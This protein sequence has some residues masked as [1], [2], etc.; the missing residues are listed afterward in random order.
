MM[1][2]D[3]WKALV[4]EEKH[5][6]VEKALRAAFGTA[7]VEEVTPLTGGG[8]GAAVLKVTVGGVPY[9]LRVI[10][11]VH[12]LND[13]ARQFVC[14][15]RASDAGISPRLHYADAADAVSITDHVAP[16]PL[17]DHPGPPLVA[18]GEAIKAIQATPT[19]PAFVNH[20]DGVDGF[21]RQV[22]AA[23]VLPEG[24][25]REHFALYA[26]LAEAYPRHDPDLVSAHND[27]NPRNVLFDGA[28]LWIIDW[29]S[30]FRNDRYADL[31]NV[32]N[33]FFTDE[34]A[35]GGPG[36]EEDQ[37]LGAYFGA[38]PSDYQR[39][40]FF[41]M[42]QVSH[43]S[44]AML[45]A[46]LALSRRPPGHPWDA[47]METPRLHEFHRRLAGHGAGPQDPLAT[48]EGLF[49][50]GKVWLNEALHHMRGPRF[51]ESLRRMR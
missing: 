33:F 50:Y 27:L 24:E 17:R 47:G 3:D 11:H 49:F 36:W 28:R 51:E 8:S 32:A 14:L 37:L 25:T 1:T 34:P 5:G 10:R 45:L 30:A 23:G 41:L 18:L 7:E 19:F 2:G 22:R 29:E 39:A 38:S 13:P 35:D 48:P 42:R 12:D 43:L 15:R 46:L 31:A 6:A 44:Y 26:R 4:P 40:R 20:L 21:I 16:V 9:V